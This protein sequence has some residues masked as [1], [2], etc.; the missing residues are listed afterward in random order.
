MGEGTKIAVEVIDM[1]YD[2]AQDR[3][4]SSLADA[5]KVWSHHQ[6]NSTADLYKVIEP[7][8]FAAGEYPMGLTHARAKG[9]QPVR[10]SR[11]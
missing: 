1:V 9:N 11:L 7:R 8:G 2:K 6:S 5:I 4:V 3:R 10:N